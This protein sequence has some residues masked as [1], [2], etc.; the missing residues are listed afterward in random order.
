MAACHVRGRRFVAGVAVC[1]VLLETSPRKSRGRA[2]YAAGYRVGGQ[3][4][5]SGTP[6]SNT[7][8]THATAESET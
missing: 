1:P 5:T 4:S 3:R 8:F 6:L 7:S 2:R